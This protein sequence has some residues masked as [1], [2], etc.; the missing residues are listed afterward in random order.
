MKTITCKKYIS[1]SC[2]SHIIRYIF[3]ELR[4]QESL[5]DNEKSKIHTNTYLSTYLLSALYCKCILVPK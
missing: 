2:I 4:R 3:A 5:S 1:V